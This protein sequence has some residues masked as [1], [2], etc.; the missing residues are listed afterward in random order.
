[1]TPNRKRK[2]GLVLALPAAVVAG[3]FIA[4]AAG[5]FGT[6]GNALPTEMQ[7]FAIFRDGA[8]EGLPTGLAQEARTWPRVLADQGRLVSSD[9]DGKLF[10]IPGAEGTVC[11][12]VTGPRGTAGGC[13]TTTR[14]SPVVQVGY[15]LPGGAEQAVVI[16]PDGYDTVS[17][18]GVRRAIKDNVAKVVVDRSGPIDISGPAGQVAVQP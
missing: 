18:A 13:G 3:A 11:L 15:H 2:L 16:A 14:R 1:V 4:G 17:Y 5:A 9:A 10:A 12:V 6:A 7:G 8:R